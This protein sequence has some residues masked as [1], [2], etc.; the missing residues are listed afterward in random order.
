V[1]GVR[2][3]DDVGVPQNVHAVLAGVGSLRLC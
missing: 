3:E 1:L 2:R